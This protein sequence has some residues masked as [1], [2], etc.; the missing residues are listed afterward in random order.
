M[1]SIEEMVAAFDVVDVNPNPARFDLK[2]AE[3]INGDHIRLLEPAD[4][5]RRIV[6]YLV[7]AGVLSEPLTDA[8]QAIL[9]AAAP[10]IQERIA[11]LGEAPGM[12]GFLFVSGDAL[13]HEAD[14]LSSLPKNAT[15]I[16]A[17]SSAALVD[18][19]ET[20]WNHERVHTRLTETLIDGLGLKPRVAFGPLRVAV[21]GRRVSPPLFESMDILGKAESVARLDRLA[22]TLAS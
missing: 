19:P 1:F 8:D 18:I 6:P 22:A 10:L 3:S 12:L 13:G 15:E 21:S 9:T 4:F 2:K 17:A 11:L 16:L 14:A 5:A 7:A 20:E